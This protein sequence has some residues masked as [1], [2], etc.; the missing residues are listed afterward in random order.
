MNV[1]SVR[2]TASVQDSLTVR[3][4]QWR[5]TGRL[6][7]ACVHVNSQHICNTLILLQDEVSILDDSV[8]FYIM[9]NSDIFS[10]QNLK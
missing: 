6:F 9:F 10:W 2:V 3:E 1:R 8:T 7:C 5:V 4:S